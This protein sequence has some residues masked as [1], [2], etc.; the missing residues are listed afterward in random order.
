MKRLERYVARLT[1]GLF[2]LL[3]LGLITLFLVIDFGD[4]L[5][6]YAGRP[7]A[8]V[9]L[10]YWYRSHLAMVQF[11]PAALVLASG[12]AVTTLRRRGEWVALRAMG[13]SSVTV[14][15][16]I[17]VVASLAALGLIAFQEFVVSE[18]GPRPIT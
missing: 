3:A 17:M 10:L 12:L 13:A 7:V 5:R 6:V 18:S 1:T 15:R 2:V 11:A 14:L 8:D 16:P 9:A 4:W